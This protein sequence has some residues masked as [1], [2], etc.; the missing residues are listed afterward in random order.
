MRRVDPTGVQSRA[1]RALHRRTYSVCA[2]NELWHLDGY[3]KLIR[4]RV[5]IHGGIDG[6]S[7][8]VTFLQAS[9][10]NKART[11]LS[12]FQAAVDEHGLP[13]RIRTDRGGE[14]VLVA[15]YMLEHPQRGPGRG[16]VITGTSTHNQRIERLWRDLFVGC[17]SFFV[18][19][20]RR[21]TAATGYTRGGYCI[22]GLGFASASN[23]ITAEC[24]SRSRGRPPFI[25]LVL[26]THGC[27]SRKAYR[28]A[29]QYSC[30]CMQRSVDIWLLLPAVPGPHCI[31]FC[32]VRAGLNLQCSYGH[33]ASGPALHSR[34]SLCLPV[35]V[36]SRASD[37]VL[38]NTAPAFVGLAV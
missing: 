30:I 4:W 37:P 16:S 2:P 29:I 8:M 22:R 38:H 31:G 25:W 35:S 27:R 36:H 10:N 1:R 19:D 5:V 3:H 20:K 11:V 6:F 7:R 14:N 18:I 13:S 32:L 9:T 23:T 33:M 28:A 12:A 26:P 21:P 17:I 24:I 15:Q 34:A